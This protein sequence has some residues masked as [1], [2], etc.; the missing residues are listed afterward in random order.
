LN[1]AVLL[2][3]LLKKTRRSAELQIEH[4]TTKPTVGMKEPTS[5]RQAV[6]FGVSELDPARGTG[7]LR[8]DG[9]KAIRMPEQPFSI[10]SMLP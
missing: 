10:L 8:K 3:S 2:C 4:C 9:V 6:C 5:I 7:E 1:F